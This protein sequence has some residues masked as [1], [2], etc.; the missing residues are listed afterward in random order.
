MLAGFAVWLPKSVA[1]TD[2]KRPNG[3]QLSVKS[4]SA[5]IDLSW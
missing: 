1:E 4:A 5:G 3:P 2:E